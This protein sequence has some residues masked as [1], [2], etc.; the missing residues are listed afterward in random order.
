[1]EL[2]LWDDFKD[3]EINEKIKY[4]VDI[5]G[6]LIKNFNK[7]SYGLNLSNPHIVIKDIIDEIE[8][9]KMRNKENKAFLLK[10]VNS[11]L[12]NDKLIK[13]CY[14]VEFESIRE[15]LNS[16]KHEYLL[17][18]CKQVKKAFENN[19]YFKRLYSRL[20]KSLLSSDEGEEIFKEI[21][22]ISQSLIV[23]L[24][25]NGFHLDSIKRMPVE[26]FQNYMVIE[27]DYIVPQYP[28]H[29]LHFNDFKDEKTY[30]EV[31]REVIDNLTIV[32]RLDALSEYV[33]G[34]TSKEY[35]VIVPIEGMIG[36]VREREIGDVLFYNPRFYQHVKRDEFINVESEEENKELFSREKDRLLN[37]RVKVKCVDWKSAKDLAND[38]LEEIFNV[39]RCIY[40]TKC[41]FKAITNRYI[42]TDLL[43]T[44]LNEGYDLEIHEIDKEMYSLDMKDIFSDSKEETFFEEVSNAM[45]QSNKIESITYQKLM[46]SL[47]WFRKGE[48][49]KR[50]EDRLL[51]YWIAMENLMDFK[52]S[53]EEGRN[54]ILN[55]EKETSFNL[56]KELIPCLE[57]MGY[58]NSILKDLFRYVRDLTYTKGYSDKA[59]KQGLE[60]PE[61]LRKQCNLIHTEERV[62][63]IPF[64]KNLEEIS[65]YTEREII[66]D[67]IHFAY[68]FYNNNK[69]AENAI[70]ERIKV[71]QDEIVYIY[72]Y[73]NKIVHNAH[74]DNALLP[75]IVSKAKEYANSLLMRIMYD[76]FIS[77]EEEL[78][79]IYFKWHFNS[80][81]FM[82]NLRGNEEI[83]IINYNFE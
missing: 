30:S 58:K 46:Y 82:K 31:V 80:S 81:I 36:D 19:G 8:F 39:L 29:R 2:F 32:Q 1:M 67:K 61:E 9:N 17:V 41:K 38:K 25:L 83:D 74:Y 75:H 53:S 40:K 16:D 14:K 54:I 45:Y 56:I 73:R 42:L 33:L 55:K 72:R 51:N 76:Y 21:N 79:D 48:E 37:A 12:K 3:G 50:A 27:N 11:F 78:K 60:L 6:E 47:H 66:K 10:Q 65:K 35:Y 22:S 5:W 18:I 71:V 70:Q 44:E 13:N 77:D 7:N 69:F 20:K 34:L 4:W 43:G 63:L 28:Y 68:Q 64:L 23:E 24:I 57:I 15:Y 26:I 59:T 62:S 49:S 52:S